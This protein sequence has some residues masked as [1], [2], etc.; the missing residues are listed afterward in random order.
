[1]PKSNA[2]SASSHMISVL[3]FKENAALR[4]LSAGKQDRTNSF[5]VET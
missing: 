3:L 2:R 1:M 5:L 4:Q